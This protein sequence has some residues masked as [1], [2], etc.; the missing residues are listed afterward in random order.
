MVER[1]HLILFVRDQ[2]RARAFW[3]AVLATPAT[4]HVPGMTELPLPGGAVLGLMPEAGIERLLDGAVRP[5]TSDVPRSEVYL[6]VADLEAAWARALAAGAR[7]VQDPA[8]RSWGHVAGYLRDPD[9][10]LLALAR[11]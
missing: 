11:A 9:G 4:L 7:V 5:S 2:E 8:P 6:V 3:E 1:A 10:H